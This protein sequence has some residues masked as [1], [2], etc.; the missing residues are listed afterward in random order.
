MALDQWTVIRI[1]PSK[2]KMITRKS[3]ISCKRHGGDGEALG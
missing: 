1:Q 2:G 3:I